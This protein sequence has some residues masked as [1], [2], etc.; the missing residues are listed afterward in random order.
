[1]IVSVMREQEEH[2]SMMDW[3][4]LPPAKESSSWFCFSNA[5]TNWTFQRQK[6]FYWGSAIKLC[7][8]YWK[9]KR[10]ELWWLNC[11]R[12]FLFKL[13]WNSWHRMRGRSSHDDNWFRNCLDL[14]LKWSRL[15]E[16][17]GIKELWWYMKIN[18]F[19]FRTLS[20]LLLS[21][22]T[23]GSWKTSWVHLF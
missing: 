2:L 5:Q 9:N 13:V 8:T 18:T 23:L 21:K 22:C 19:I 6:T 12:F 16:G 11:F 20:N 15:L 17:L 3:S 4:F 14:I 1:M 7:S 10:H